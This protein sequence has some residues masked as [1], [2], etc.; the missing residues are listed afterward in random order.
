MSELN[1]TRNQY[2]ELEKLATGAFA[3]LTRF[4]VEDEF[5]SV[6]GDMRLLSGEVFPLPVVLNVDADTAARFA[7]GPTVSLTFGGEEVGE[8]ATELRKSWKKLHRPERVG[9]ELID[10]T[11]YLLRFANWFE[12]DLE[13]CVREKER[14]NAGRTWTF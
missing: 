1:L 4:M 12:I 8:I 14:Q 13:A 11:T 7:G 3:P 10:A 6:V 5:H 2:L 9:G